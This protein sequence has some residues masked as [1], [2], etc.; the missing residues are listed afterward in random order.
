MSRRLDNRSNEITKS[1]LV[2]HCIIPTF[3]FHARVVRSDMEVVS[4]AIVDIS[5]PELVE[6]EIDNVVVGFVTL[7][8]V[9]IHT[10][11]QKG[12]TLFTFGLLAGRTVSVT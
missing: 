12:E 4:K 9:F 5:D 3:A 8:C 6:K 2:A 11:S 10:K 1:E 7:R